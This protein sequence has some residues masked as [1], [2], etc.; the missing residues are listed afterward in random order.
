MTA[1]VITSGVDTYLNGL[2]GASNYASAAY[3]AVRS[4]P[5]TVEKA[6]LLQMPSIPLGVVILSATLTVPVRSTVAA[7]S[8]LLMARVAQSWSVS[9]VTWNTA[10][11]TV[12]LPTSTSVPATA[13]GGTISIDVT[14]LVQTISS[15][16]ANYGWKLYLDTAGT[17]QEIDFYGFDSGHAS[18]TLTIDVSDLP[19]TPTDLVPAGVVSLNKWVCQIGDADDIAQIRVEV[20]PAASSTPAFDSGWVA[21]TTPTL[22]LATTAY[23]GL[24]DGSSTYWRAAFKTSTGATS[25]FSD[26]VQVT[27]HVKPSVVMDVPP[28]GLV[29]HSAPT[30]QA[31][32]SPAGSST[33]RWRVRLLSAT[34]ASKVLYDS[35]DD[36]TG[37]TLAQTIPHRWRN[38]AVISKDGTYR[39]QV[40]CWDRSDRVGSY[41]DAPYELVDETLTVDTDGTIAVP[42]GLVVSQVAAGAPDVLL[43]W[44]A[45][46]DPDYFLAY[47]DGEK[48][49][50]QIDPSA[51][52]VSPGVFEWVDATAT[53]NTATTWKIK[54]VVGVKQSAASTGVTFTPSV[55]GIWLRSTLGTVLLAGDD[56]DSIK[57]TDK[58]IS[59]PLPYA[60]EDIDVVTSVAGYSVDSMTLSIDSRLVWSAPIV[61]DVD[62]AR[63]ILEQIRQSPAKPVQLI[64]GTVSIPV[65]LRGLSVAPYSKMIPARD[66]THLITFGFFETDD[67]EDAGFGPGYYGAGTYF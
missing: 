44:T 58:R 31:H 17:T 5:S 38:K 66:R 43:H 47:R 24:A 54:A 46:A 41:G 29:Y 8:T 26:W 11:A 34:D 35:G 52:R 32:L 36:I 48:I 3:P 23:A 50:V 62:D 40:Y 51:A 49:P 22:D 20:D 33:T 18:W 42:T 30:I 4:N 39:L 60:F 53:P 63:A 27:R 56:V 1:T 64:W 7:G 28:A 15:G 55:T 45:G 10:P 14:S 65:Y 6:T 59:Y 16:A 57:Q 12:G 61:Q 37:A 9:K 21:T 67:V 19:T 2:N 13:A 25:A